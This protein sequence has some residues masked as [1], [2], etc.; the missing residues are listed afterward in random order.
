MTFLCKDCSVGAYEFGE[1]LHREQQFNAHTQN[2]QKC[3]IVASNFWLRWLPV[4]PF[5]TCIHLQKICNVGV[6]LD[7]TLFFPQQSRVTP[8]RTSPTFPI[9]NAYAYS[10]HDTIFY[11]EWVT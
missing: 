2:I 11:L 5:Y 1:N 10:L 4:K 7:N 9:N 8:N 6:V 3:F